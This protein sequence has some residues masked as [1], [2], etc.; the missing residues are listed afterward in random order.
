MILGMPWIRAQDVRIN[1]PRSEMKIMSTGVVVRSQDAFFEIEKTVCRAVQVSA[2]SFHEIQTR[3]KGRK[4]LQTDRKKTTVFVASMAD[5]NKALAVKRY[6]NP[7]EK[8][9]THYHDWLDVADRKAA[10]RLP[11]VRGIGVDH[12]IE[13]ERDENGREKEPP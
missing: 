6:T 2:I 12:A 5:I 13:L 11:P 4:S 10:E 9:P 1:G 3:K 8:M 7:K